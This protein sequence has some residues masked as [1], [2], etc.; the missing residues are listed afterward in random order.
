MSSLLVRQLMTTDVQT[1][2][3]G[4]DVDFAEMVMRLE[5]FRHLPVVD[6]DGVLVGVISDR[7]I[8]SSQVSGLSD[9]PVQ[10][11]RMISMRIPVAE[12][13]TRDISTIPP[14]AHALEAAMLIRERKIN[15]IPVVDDGKLVGI[16]TASDFLDLAIRELSDTRD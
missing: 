11:R 7:D 8:L 14:D 15:C 5:R 10:E 3:A 1:I 2:E 6:D 12:I 16:V 13:M 9:V 4:D